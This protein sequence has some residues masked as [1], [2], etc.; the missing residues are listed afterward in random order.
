VLSIQNST[1]ISEDIFQRDGMEI[2]QVVA[3]NNEVVPT[4]I[5]AVSYK[6]LGLLYYLWFAGDPEVLK[7]AE[8]GIQVILD[9]FNIY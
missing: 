8:E 1:L 7:N 4:D 3:E 2:Y 5:L 6:K 9:S